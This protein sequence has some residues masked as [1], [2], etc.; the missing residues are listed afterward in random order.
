MIDA[1]H[2]RH[3][4]LYGHSDG[5]SIAL[6]SAGSGAVAPAALVLQAP[7][8]FVEDVTVTNIAALRG[9]Y[10]S[11]DLRE[12]LVKH[13]GSN[14]DLLFDAWTQVWLSNEFRRWNI[15]DALPA[16]ARPMLI[17]QGTDDE[18]GT[19]RQVEAIAHG[20]T[21]RVETLVLDECGHSPH[22]DRADDVIRAA[23]GF[24]A[25]AGV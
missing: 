1:F 5:A 11:G 12:R 9:Q 7:H 23:A 25:N 4:V 3:L 22:I 21:G 2:I 17:I 18:Y 8:V 24:L 20:A 16:I 10:T 13:H 6:I 14:T 15:E 19:P